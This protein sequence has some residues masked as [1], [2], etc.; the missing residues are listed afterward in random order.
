L[1]GKVFHTGTVLGYAAQY[2]AV[3][4]VVSQARGS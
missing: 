1:T 3:W 2:A 4:L